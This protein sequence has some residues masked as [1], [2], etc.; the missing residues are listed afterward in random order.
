MS[1]GDC[2]RRGVMGR[3]GAA[4][5]LHRYRVGHREKLASSA[6]GDALDH[7][8]LLARG[9]HAQLPGLLLD[10]A[11]SAELPQPRLK[12]VVLGLHYPTDVLVGA[13]LGAASG[14]TGAAFS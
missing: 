5:G 14:A 7:V 10:G 2:A 6:A 3:L 13:L 4:H 11:R 9:D 8:G 12:R 1:L